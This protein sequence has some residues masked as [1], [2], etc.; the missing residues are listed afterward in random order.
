MCQSI[1]INTFRK[2]VSQ[3]GKPTTQEWIITIVG[4]RM[5]LTTREMFITGRAINRFQM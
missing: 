2:G 3:V 1:K 5:S 4:F